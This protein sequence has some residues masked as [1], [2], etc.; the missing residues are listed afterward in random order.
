[1][2]FPILRFTLSAGRKLKFPFAVAL[3]ILVFSYNGPY[4]FNSPSLKCIIAVQIIRQQEQF[5]NG[6]NGADREVGQSKGYPSYPAVTSDSLIIHDLP[7]NTCIVSDNNSRTCVLT[8]QSFN[9]MVAN[10]WINASDVDT[11]RKD[12]V[13]QMLRM[14]FFDQQVPRD[15][16]LDD[17]HSDRAPQPEDKEIKQRNEPASPDTD[18]LKE[19]YDFYYRS[20]F[21]PRLSYC[22]DMI[23]CTDSALID[24]LYS[25]LLAKDSTASILPDSFLVKGKDTVACRIGDYWWFRIPET[26]IP[27]HQFDKRDFIPQQGLSKPVHS[28]EGSFIFRVSQVKPIEEVTI[29]EAQ[30]LLGR[31]VQLHAYGFGSVEA[32]ALKYYHLKRKEFIR[33]FDV[34]LCL[35][36]KPRNCN[37]QKVELAQLQRKTLSQI[38][39]QGDTVSLDNLPEILS[40]LINACLAN[41]KVDTSYLPL[42]TEFGDVWFSI[43][44]TITAK[45]RPFELIKDSLIAGILNGTISIDCFGKAPAR[46]GKLT[47]NDY[48][49]IRTVMPK[50]KE[51]QYREL[52][53]EYE[54]MMR[55]PNV[56]ESASQIY[57]E[58]LIEKQQKQIDADFERWKETLEIRLP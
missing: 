11:A 6:D 29:S 38:F 16:A 39:R 10:C 46:K 19:A 48:A 41:R 5:A 57:I 30:K 35:V 53:K 42:S 14:M 58:S 3:S 50:Y 1:M 7:K 23:A 13:L 43:L 20:C 47:R 22:V 4:A 49:R 37:A 44:D 21:A 17:G 55:M 52:M 45:V 27:W 12:A 8:V 31:L 26:E 15:S 36:I 40:A 2:T 33:P 28:K 34:R 18:E 56:E 51:K 54:T 9:T 25:A 24:S 32:A